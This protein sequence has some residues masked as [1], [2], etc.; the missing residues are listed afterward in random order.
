MQ[1]GGEN[2]NWSMLELKILFVVCV[3]F[4]ALVFCA[5]CVCNFDFKH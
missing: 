4:V 1:E 2:V 5:R 3:M